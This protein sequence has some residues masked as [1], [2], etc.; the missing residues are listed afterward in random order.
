MIDSARP[1]NNMD[2]EMS[3]ENSKFLICILIDTN[4]WR[5]TLLLRS[6]LGPALMHLVNSM[7]LKIA[8]PEVVE[9]EIHKQILDMAIDSCH[10]IERGFRDLGAVLGA[11]RP[12]EIPT[13][14]DIEGA[15]KKRF[16]DLDKFIVRIYFTLEHA[17]NALFRVNHRIPPSSS[18]SQQFKDAAIWE[19]ALEL[20]EGY[21]LL[22]ITEDG[23][24]FDD[25]DRRIINRKL[26]MECENLGISIKI[27]S[28]L[29]I[30]LKDLREKAPE[31][32]YDSIANSIHASIANQ[33]SQS[34]SR[35]G[36]RITKIQKP[37]IS[38][39]ITEDHDILAIEFDM[40][41]DTIDIGGT[42]DSKKLNPVLIV[43]GDGKYIISTKSAV[44]TRIHSIE[45]RWE[46]EVGETLKVRDIFVHAGTMY[47]GKQPDIPYSV[48]KK[49]E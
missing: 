37:N 1:Q 26:A 45:T 48:K 30:L 2:Y 29:S 36:L 33:L 9:G 39:F 35:N 15:I 17:K 24:F 23:D 11:H 41:F 10:K 4:I 14:K 32:D 31:L 12:Y 38:A 21:K 40:I 6:G 5:K 18:K 13:Q 8:L 16:E 20:G 47:I 46:N 27:Y 19:A 7:G 43:E 3:N 49:I 28:D 25:K 44:E 42:S 34:A 22:F